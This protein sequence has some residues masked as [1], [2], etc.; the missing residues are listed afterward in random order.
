M[1]QNVAYKSTEFENK[2]QQANET[3]ILIGKVSRETQRKYLT[4][5]SLTKMNNNNNA[6]DHRRR[7]TG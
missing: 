2:E 5:F 3:K 1:D 4:V 7:C 6:F